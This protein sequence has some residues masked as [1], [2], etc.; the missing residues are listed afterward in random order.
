[1]KP[2]IN[3]V[4]LLLAVV[5]GIGCGA[6]LKSNG[7]SQQVPSVVKAQRFDLV[8]QSGNTR[9][10]MSVDPATGAAGISF[11]DGLNTLPR[12][13]IGT[14]PDNSAEISLRDK[15]GDKRAELSL[16]GTTVRLSLLD[17]A[18]KGGV[19]LGSTADRTALLFNDDTSRH[20]AAFGLTPAHEP[21]LMM[22]DQNQKPIWS[23]PPEI[24]K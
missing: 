15:N 1:M 8:D 4:V 19:I 16:R 6:Q 13:L 23:A 5:A 11:F 2:G 24:H 21:N 17:V 3:T 18:L 20:R 22:Y 7:A 9:I 10:S 12:I 14:L